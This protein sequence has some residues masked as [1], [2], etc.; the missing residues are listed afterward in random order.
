MNRTFLDVS[1]DFAD[2]IAGLRRKN[3][4]RTDG[5]RRNAGHFEDSCEVAKEEL[6]RRILGNFKHY[7]PPVQLVA[8]G[9]WAVP[10]EKRPRNWESMGIP[11]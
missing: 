11:E 10:V 6:T 8:S 9:R 7:T 2:G 1:G 5:Q 4:K 3:T